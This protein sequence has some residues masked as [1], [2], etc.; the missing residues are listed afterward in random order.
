MENNN[1]HILD[2]NII[3]GMV[4]PNDD[5][6]ENAK[7]YLELDY[8]PY[9]STTSYKE[10]EEKIVKIRK[11]SLN[12]NEYIKNYSIENNINLLNI[13]KIRLI[14]KNNFLNQFKNKKYPV[15]LSEKGFEQIVTNF[16][17]NYENEITLV[18]IS[19]NNDELSKLIKET[20]RESNVN[21]DY[22]IS[23]QTCITFY[24]DGGKV[25][26][27]EKIG[28]HKKDAILLDEAY[29]LHLTLDEPVNFIT[30]DS[31]VLELKTDVSTVIQNVTV[32]NPIEFIVYN[33]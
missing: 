18:L 10:A 15:S 32:S 7:K 2:T 31:E 6:Y 24:S 9:V 16:F 17:N 21:L 8:R 11:L 5:S 26:P 19:Q 28:I 14:V 23:E 27:L 25:D 22:F 4:L 20:F 30:F 29:Q 3:L 1:N 12:I 13:P 33:N